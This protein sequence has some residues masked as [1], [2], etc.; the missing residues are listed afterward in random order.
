MF[1]HGWLGLVWLG[2]VLYTTRWY[3]IVD[4]A[5]QQDTTYFN[6]NCLFVKSMHTV[7]K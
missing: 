5:V 6:K 2:L 3:D 1:A 7:S 4:T